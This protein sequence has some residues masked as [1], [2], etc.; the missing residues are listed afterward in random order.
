MQIAFCSNFLSAHQRPLCDALYETADCDFRFIASK[1]LSEIRKSMG[2]KEEQTPYVIPSYESETTYQA[3]IDYINQSDVVMV[4]GDENDQ[5]FKIAIKNKNTL[6]F[7]FC[8]RPYKNGRWRA[9]S[10]RGI[11]I[12]WNSYYK[13]PKQNLFMLCSS[14]YAAGDYALLGSY[15]G[16]C[17]KWGYFTEVKPLD[18]E[19]ISAQ[20]EDNYIFWAGR[21]LDW[22]HPEA[23]VRVGLFL[24]EHNIPFRMGIAG[25][26]PMR[27]PL[28]QLIAE[29]GLTEQ[30][31]LL[32]T[33]SQ[34]ETQAHMQ[35]AGIYL[36]TSDYREGWGAVVGE[37]MSRG[38]AVVACEAMGAV[39][40]LI[41]NGLN[42]FSYPNKDEKQL[43]QAVAQLLTDTSLRHRIGQQAYA[44]MHDLWNP[45]I[46]AQRLLQLIAAIKNGNRQ[47]F[48]EGPCSKAQIFGKG[49]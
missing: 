38:C 6:I 15:L 26:G 45:R 27:E 44:T 21:L 31:H 33:L 42:G 40:F 43:C 39:P 18:I 25:D 34:N 47:P 41:K 10:P 46:A 22:K 23:A 20:K 24:K 30:I 32:G 3:A 36:A 5:F 9:V 4:S 8:E 16:R 29:N 12:R 48:E 28:Q 7:R 37:A 49:R 14:A 1:P 2:W 35:K 19:H 11:R 13:H 17:Y